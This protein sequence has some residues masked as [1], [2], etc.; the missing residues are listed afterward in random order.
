MPPETTVPRPGRVSTRPVSRN[1]PMTRVAVAIATP[2][3]AMICL[4][5]GTGAP[6]GSEPSVICAA[7]WAAIRRYRGSTALVHHRAKHHV[8]WWG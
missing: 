7:I 3:D 2:Y 6:G 5:E 1:W 8:E 4:V